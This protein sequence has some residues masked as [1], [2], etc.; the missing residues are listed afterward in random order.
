MSRIRIAK[1]T[2]LSTTGAAVV[3]T[4][5]TTKEQKYINGSDGQIVK[6]VAGE[7][8]FAA[9]G[10]SEAVEH[11]SPT[12]GATSVTLSNTPIAGTLKM[13]RNG[14]L[15]KLTTDYTISG[16]TVTLVLA[17][18]AS[19]GATYGEEISANYKY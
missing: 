5:G 13:Y 7:I 2:E 4:D 14:R 16:V 1:E 8:V 18:G 12:T 6:M 19:T 10:G 11:F 3:V 15:M 17:T 9:E